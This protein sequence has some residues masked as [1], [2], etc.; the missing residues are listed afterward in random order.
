MRTARLMAR[1]LLAASLLAA[2]AWPL[3]SRPTLAER[4]VWAAAAALLLIN[5]TPRPTPGERTRMG[6]YANRKITM[7]FP[8]LSE[9]DDMVRVT[10]RNP[11]TLPPAELRPPDIELDAA[12]KPVDSEAAE[13]ATYTAI[14]K[15]ISGWHV[16]DAT[17]DDDDQPPLP[18][19]A[20]PELVA[21]LPMEIISKIA[22]AMTEAI[23]P[24]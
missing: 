2:A 16:Y 24:Q 8:D 14:S 5:P 13:Q 18:L 7:E 21:K 23:N 20:T 12:G 1:W 3:A 4:L 17:S 15:L 19:P 6:G 11:R 9:D 10:I 22:E